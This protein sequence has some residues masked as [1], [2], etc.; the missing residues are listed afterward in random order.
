MPRLGL[1]PLVL[2]CAQAMDPRDGILNGLGVP[3]MDG[4]ELAGGHVL[5]DG[6]TVR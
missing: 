1:V 2:I 3:P 5:L 6:N 4:V